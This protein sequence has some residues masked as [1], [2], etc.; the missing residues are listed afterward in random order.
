MSIM[1]IISNRKTLTGI[2]S[3]LESFPNNWHEWNLAWDD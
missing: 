2:V 1:C 3:K